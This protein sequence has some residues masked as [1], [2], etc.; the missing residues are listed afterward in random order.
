MVYFQ[1]PEHNKPTHDLKTVQSVFSNTQGLHITGTAL[2]DAAALGYGSEGIIETIQS[3]EAS[4]FYKSMPS[5]KK[6]GTWQ[7]VY[8]VPDGDI[9]LYV[10]FTSDVVTEFRLLSFKER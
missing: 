5:E 3:I 2:R 10:K 8:R 6:P 4:H 1:M 7:D 9:E